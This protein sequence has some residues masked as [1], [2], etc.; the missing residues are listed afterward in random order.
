MYFRTIHIALF[1]CLI[2]GFVS[3]PAHSQQRATID[4]VAIAEKAI[5]ADNWPQVDSIMAKHGMRHGKLGFTAKFRFYYAQHDSAYY[6]AAMVFPAKGK[7]LISKLQFTSNYDA[8]TVVNSLLSRGY[9]YEGYHPIMT[10]VSGWYSRGDIKVNFELFPNGG[11]RYEV[12]FYLNG[13]SSK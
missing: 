12:T 11:P 2:T 1:V 3:L 13:L 4:I 8:D 9:Q 7:K 6:Y 5:M 10:F